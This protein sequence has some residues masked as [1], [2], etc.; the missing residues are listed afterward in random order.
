[1]KRLNRAWMM[2]LGLLGV[3]LQVV[4]QSDAAQDNSSFL[5]QG[6][7]T[8]VSGRLATNMASGSNNLQNNQA[9]IAVGQYA[10]AS[11][12]AQTSFVGT[13]AAYPDAQY[14][15]HIESQSLARTSGLI[16]INQASGNSNAQ[17]NLMT[18]VVGEPI[19]AVGDGQLSRA[20]PSAR[21]GGNAPSA[22]TQPVVAL[23]PD[24][25]VGS[26]GVVQINQIAGGGNASVIEMTMRVAPNFNVR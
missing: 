20:V 11:V 17:T 24:A 23:A 25:L 8:G 12:S 14:S 21:A 9:A 16:S 3:S 1:M 2:L 7:F 19:G 22:R 6:A 10:S 26:R 13:A 4:A 5:G 15:A 18:L